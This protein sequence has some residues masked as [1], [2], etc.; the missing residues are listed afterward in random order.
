MVCI[1]IHYFQDWLNH[2]RIYGEFRS[3]GFVLKL[4]GV[5]SSFVFGWGVTTPSILMEP[6]LI[7]YDKLFTLECFRKYL[8]GWRMR[9][10][11]N[12]SQ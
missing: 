8:L 1:Y 12:E 4:Q 11:M 6:V 10:R 5:Q 3:E 9:V 2:V 7:L